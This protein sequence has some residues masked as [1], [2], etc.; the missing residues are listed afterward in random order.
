MARAKLKALAGIAPSK[1]KPEMNTKKPSQPRVLLADDD[2]S[3]LD[4]LGAVLESEGF[5]V[6]RAANGHEAVEKFCEHRADLV[7]LDI[8][9]PVKG[10]WDTFE[11]LTSIDPL[12]PVIV[13]TARPDAYPAAMAAGVAALMQ[14]PLD[15]PVLLE[16]MRYFLTQTAEQRLSRITTHQPQTHYLA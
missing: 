9:M 12:L 6:I 15:I 16:A 4:A 8:N 11:R 3:V 10:G 1:R 14:K 13:I 2:R 7:L 5:E